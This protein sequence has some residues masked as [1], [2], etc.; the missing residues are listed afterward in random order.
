MILATRSAKQHLPPDH[1]PDL[2][3]VFKPGILNTVVFLVSN[4][5]QVCV[6]VVN[7]QG[8]PFMTG[9]TENRPLLWSLLGTFILTFMFATE[10]AP[11]LNKY[12]QLVA[13]PDDQFRDYVLSLLVFDVFATFLLDRLLKFTFCPKILMSSVEGTTWKDVLG[14]SRTIAVMVFLMYSFLGNNDQW[15]Q[16]MLQEGRFEEL[17]LNGTNMTNLTNVSIVDNVIEKV[18]DAIECAGDTCKST[19]L[20]GISDEF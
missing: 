1:E 10:T 9:L 7:L 14:L 4:V 17:G 16:L 2:D 13:F 20:Q 12:F 5:Q 3:G 6:F 8:R 15:E 19:F 18:T 11:G